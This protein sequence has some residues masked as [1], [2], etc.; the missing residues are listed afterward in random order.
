MKPRKLG[1][2]LHHLLWT[3]HWYSTGYCHSLR[4]LPYMKVTL[5]EK[6]HNAL[7]IEVPPIPTPTGVTAKRICFAILHGLVVGELNMNDLPSKRVAFVMNNLS[8]KDKA[9]YDALLRQYRFFK[10]RGL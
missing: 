7:H 4:N 8:S 10:R 6:L 2:N 5:K 3:R 1:S 9:T